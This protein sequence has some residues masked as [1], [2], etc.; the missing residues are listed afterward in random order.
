MGE[1]RESPLCPR[2]FP[3]SF[4]K[5]FQSCFRASQKV[6]LTFDWFLLPSASPKPSKSSPEL[7]QSFPELP[8]SFPKAFPQSFSPELASDFMFL[9]CPENLLKLASQGTFP[10]SP[11]MMMKMRGG[12]SGFS[13]CG[14]SKS[15]RKLALRTQNGNHLGSQNGNQFRTSGTRWL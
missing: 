2:A 6:R 11:Q 8:Q 12:R 9:G 1:V 10:N 5:V 14:V 13:R 3:Q 4:P 15:C 7:S